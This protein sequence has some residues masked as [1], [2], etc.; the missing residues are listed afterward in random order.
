VKNAKAQHREKIFSKGGL[1]QKIIA[2]DLICFCQ[3]KKKSPRNKNFNRCVYQPKL[4]FEHDAVIERINNY[5]IAV[6]KKKTIGVN[7]SL[8]KK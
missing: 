3:R 5:M 8:M 1:W 7:G 2:T 4:L 6:W